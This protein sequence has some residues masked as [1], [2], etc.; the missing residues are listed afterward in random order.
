MGGSQGG[1]RSTLRGKPHTRGV[2]GKKQ[3]G[4]SSSLKR[5]AD[6]VLAHATN[7]CMPHSPSPCC[8]S[9]VESMNKDKALEM[10]IKP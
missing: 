2:P 7:I 1:G 3:W 8:E 4:V 6:G 9:R 10:M 5:R